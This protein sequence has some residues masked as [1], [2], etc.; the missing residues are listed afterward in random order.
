[1]A[2]ANRAIDRGSKRT[3]QMVFQQIIKDK[4]KKKIQ[5]KKFEL[6]NKTK[7]HKKLLM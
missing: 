6:A 3:R 1:M 5:N 7:K 4:W 2:L